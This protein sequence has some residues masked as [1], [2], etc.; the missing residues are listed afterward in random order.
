VILENLP[1]K[2]MTMVGENKREYRKVG[3]TSV[4]AGRGPGQLAWYEYA[5]RFVKGKTV[6]DVGCGLGKGLII[7]GRTASSVTGQ[8]L[9]PRLALDNVM[10]KPLAEIPDKSYDIVTSIDVVE[11]VEDDRDYAYQICRIAREAIFVTTPNWTITRCAWPYHI[12]EYTPRQLEALFEPFG[13]VHLYKGNAAGT[14]V[15]PVKHAE[16]YH[17]ANRLRTHILAQYLVRAVNKVLR[18][19]MRLLGHNAALIDLRTS[20]T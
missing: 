10:I 6:L 18:E 3:D 13:K 7:L 20:T 14:I 8:D 11:H 15:F 4:E 19:E 2:D 5:L 16:L 17:F 12:R 1:T 9:D